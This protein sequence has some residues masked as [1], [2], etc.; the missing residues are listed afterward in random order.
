VFEAASADDRLE[1][2][3]RASDVLAQN[4]VGSAQTE[5][6]PEIIL[7]KVGQGNPERCAGAKG[8]N[9]VMGENGVKGVKGWEPS[10]TTFRHKRLFNY[11][12]IRPSLNHARQ[13]LAVD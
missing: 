2:D 8:E 11:F 4:M 7:R 5:V 10:H 9:G 6:L 1:I 3:S 12:F 13:R